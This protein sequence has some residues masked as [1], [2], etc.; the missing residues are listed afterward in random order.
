LKSSFDF[1]Y[2]QESDSAYLAIHPDVRD[3]D[4]VEQVLIERAGQGDIIIDFDTR[5]RILGVEVIGAR[6]LFSARTLAN[7]SP[8]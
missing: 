4:A 5:G 3:G 1:T 2:E 6:S 7:A 8:Q